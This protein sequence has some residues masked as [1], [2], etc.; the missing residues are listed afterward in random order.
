MKVINPDIRMEV[1]HFLSTFHISKKKK[2][3]APSIAMQPIKKV[4]AT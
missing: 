4:K 2:T 1:L 3:D